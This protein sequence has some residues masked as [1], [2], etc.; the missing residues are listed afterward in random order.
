MKWSEYCL[1]SRISSMSQSDRKYAHIYLNSNNGIV[2]LTETSNHPISFEYSEVFEAALINAPIE[3]G[4]ILPGWHLSESAPFFKALQHINRHEEKIKQITATLSEYYNTFQPKNTQEWFGVSLK[5]PIWDNIPPWGSV[6]PWRA[7]SIESYQSAIE[8]AIKKENFRDGFIKGIESGWPMCG[9]VQKPKIKV[10]AQRLLAIFQSIQENGY[11]RNNELDGD[12]K[13]TAL[14]D[15]DE[16][17]WKW[18]VTS[19]YHRACAL[20][21]MKYSSVPVRINNVIHVQHSHLWPHVQSGLYTETE[22]I[23]IFYSIFNGRSLIDNGK[24]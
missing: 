6:L 13:A 3:D 10:E 8:N 1:I 21:A 18:L 24:A 15:K 7:R 17:T 4:R 19:G 20:S 12:I 11:L 5:N 2:D 16:Y 14:I 23:E 9:P 22:A